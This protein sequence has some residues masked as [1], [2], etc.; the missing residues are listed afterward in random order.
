MSSEFVFRPGLV[1]SDSLLPFGEIFAVLFW[2]FEKI[3][4]VGADMLFQ[5]SNI[6]S[7]PP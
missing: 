2:I 4:F 1:E 3:L 5:K 7:T 6:Q